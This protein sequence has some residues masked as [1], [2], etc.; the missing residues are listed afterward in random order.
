MKK[1]SNLKNLILSAMFLA[2]AF[3]AL[4]RVLRM[5]WTEMRL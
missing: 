3:V 4:G 5:I 2:L 1:T